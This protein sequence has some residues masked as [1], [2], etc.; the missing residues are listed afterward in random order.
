MSWWNRVAELTD[1]KEISIV[2]I[3][4]HCFEKTKAYIQENRVDFP[5]YWVRDQ[6]KFEKENKLLGVPT[7][8]VLNTNREIEKIWPGVL[9][10]DKIRELIMTDSLQLSMN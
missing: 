1:E 5:V 3:S 6:K 7:T 9:S 4:V 10:E 2:G 8:I